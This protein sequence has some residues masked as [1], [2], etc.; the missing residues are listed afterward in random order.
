MASY[1]FESSGSGALAGALGGAGIG[2]AVGGPL[3]A[4]IGGG[5]GLLAGF[6]T[7]PK[8]KA[9]GSSIN[10]SKELDKIGDL[11]RE[12]RAAVTRGIEEDLAGKKFSLASSL[13][14]R[15]IYSSP[16]SEYGYRELDRGAQNALAQAL[17]GPG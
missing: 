17:A 9:P 3:G 10:I 13:A 2:A 6:F 8:R 5:A 12:Q 14:G 16:V 15:G 4:A 11:F 1:D 7:S